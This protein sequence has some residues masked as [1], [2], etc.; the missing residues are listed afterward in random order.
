[1]DE[2]ELR[3][4]GHASIGIRLGLYKFDGQ[5]QLVAAIEGSD[6]FWPLNEECHLGDDLVRAIRQLRVEDIMAQPV[7]EDRAPID[8]GPTE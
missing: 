2:L 7:F 4:I 3:E 6:E 1:M 5:V 8:G